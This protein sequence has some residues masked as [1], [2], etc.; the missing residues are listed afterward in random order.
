M[1]YETKG[2]LIG[3]AAAPELGQ[4]VRAIVGRSRDV[5]HVNELR[6]MHMA[7]ND[8]LLA[9]SL[10]FHDNLNAGRVEQTIFRLEQDIKSRFP[11]V[12]RLFIEVQSR[13][14]HDR[15][16]AAESSC[17]SAYLRILTLRPLAIS[18]KFSGD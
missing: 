1:A 14:D 11:D 5:R 15:V 4:G 16:V 3:E 10:D 6:S 12:K 17:R 9:L 8:I 2:L 7:P 18:V 13:R